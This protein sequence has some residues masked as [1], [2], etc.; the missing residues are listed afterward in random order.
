MYGRVSPPRAWMTSTKQ[1]YVVYA[2]TR[3]QRTTTLSTVKPRT[4]SCAPETEA[5]CTPFPTLCAFCA[6]RQVGFS[7]LRDSEL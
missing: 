1:G 4:S 6:A 5:S 2:L 3:M 7:F